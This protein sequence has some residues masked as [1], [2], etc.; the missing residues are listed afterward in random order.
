MFRRHH[1]DCAPF[2]LLSSSVTWESHGCLQ[3]PL[4]LQNFFRF[5]SCYH[6]T[7]MHEQCRLLTNDNCSFFVKFSIKSRSFGC[8]FVRQKK[9]TW[10]FGSFGVRVRLSFEIR[11]L[12]E[13]FIFTTAPRISKKSNV[14]TKNVTKGNATKFFFDTKTTFCS[15]PLF[16]VYKN[17]TMQ[18]QRYQ[19]VFPK[20]QKNRRSPVF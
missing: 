13:I 9:I 16:F 7:L 17:D 2:L 15:E 5:C 18:Q 10:L 4:R 3:L 11:F 8:S 19:V 12:S 6:E 14:D 1:S 20:Q